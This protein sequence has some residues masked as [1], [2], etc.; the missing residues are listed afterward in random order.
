MIGQIQP[1][2][3][4]A[5]GTTKFLN[6]YRAFLRTYVDPR[7][8]IRLGKNRLHRFLDR[9]HRR[10]FDPERTEKIFGAARS[11]TQLLDV[12]LEQGGGLLRSRSGPTRGLHGA[13][14]HGG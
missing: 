8:V 10:C 1:T 9:R 7:Q 11:G 4:E 6:A 3:M 2:L 14:S 13:R 12:Q 5:L